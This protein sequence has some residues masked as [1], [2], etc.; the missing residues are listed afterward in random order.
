MK[1]CINYHNIDIVGV[2]YQLFVSLHFLIVGFL[3]SEV[4]VCSRYFSMQCIKGNSLNF[5][6][7]EAHFRVELNTW[8]LW[9]FIC[10]GHAQRVRNV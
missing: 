10:N 3:I 1:L 8:G 5:Q 6:C 9:Y 7:L 4:Q 2:D